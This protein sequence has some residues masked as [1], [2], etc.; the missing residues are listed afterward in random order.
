MKPNETSDKNKVLKAIREEK[1]ILSSKERW[2]GWIKASMASLAALLTIYKRNKSDLPQ[3][4]PE[5]FEQ[6]LPAVSSKHQLES[7]QDPGVQPGYRAW[8]W[9][10]FE[11]LL[12][13]L[14]ISPSHPWLGT[15]S[16]SPPSQD[17][18]FLVSISMPFLIHGSHTHFWGSLVCNWHW[19]KRP[20]PPQLGVTWNLFKKQL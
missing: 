19:P 2:L 13:H 17:V 10:G 6:S 4:L 14:S 18:S 5:D 3:I 11:L 8:P 9:R 1:D 12:F 20:E 15:A 7:S 16:R